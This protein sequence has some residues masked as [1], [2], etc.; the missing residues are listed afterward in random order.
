MILGGGGAMDA[1]KLGHGGAR[2]AAVLEVED[3]LRWPC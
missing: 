2:E 3:K 1:S